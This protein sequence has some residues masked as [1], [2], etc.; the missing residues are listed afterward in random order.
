MTQTRIHGLGLAIILALSLL[1]V[2][3]S[4]EDGIPVGRKGFSVSDG[5]TVKYGRQLVRMFGIDAPEK[6]QTCDD[7]RWLPGPL[8]TEALKRFIGGRQVACYE[9]D[10]DKRNK[11][12][13]ALCYVGND[14]LQALMVS[15]GWAW[16]FTQFSDQYVDAERRAARRGVGV[17]AHRCQPPWEWR[18]KQRA[19][20]AP[21]GVG[22]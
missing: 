12:P 16:A 8:A 17:H 15:A 4:A 9:V 2:P 22:K 11:R 3:A 6:G 18:A 14:D 21:D 19:Q 13:V 7:G 5:D 20:R 10:Y 1:A